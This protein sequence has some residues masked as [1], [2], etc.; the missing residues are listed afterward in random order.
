MIALY[1]V[2]A[3]LAA[4]GFYLASAHQRLWR[5]ARRRAGFEL[6]LVCAV[7][8]ALVPVAGFVGAGRR[9]HS[10]RHQGR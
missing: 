4:T 10:P 5:D 1:L 8:T 3:A 9:L 7:L 2:L 6:L